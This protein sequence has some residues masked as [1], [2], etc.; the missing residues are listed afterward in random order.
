VG[1]SLSA[2]AAFY[3][4][5]VDVAQ[6][7]S[8]TALGVMDTLLALAGFAAPALTGWLVERTGSF[9]APFWLLA[10]LALSSVLVVLLFHHP[11]EARFSRA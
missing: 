5:N 8:G 2:N 3:A 6:H 7:R 10:C 1:L 4:I 9:A 11:D